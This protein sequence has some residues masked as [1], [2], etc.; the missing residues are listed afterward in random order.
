TSSELE[1]WRSAAAVRQAAD[2]A[3][4]R[5]QADRR[6]V[7][8]RRIAAAGRRLHQSRHLLRRA[9]RSGA[10]R[11]RRPGRTDDGDTDGQ[12]HR[13]DAGQDRPS[14]DDRQG[15]A[16]T[17]R[18]RGDSKASRCLSD[19]GRRRGLPGLE[20]DQ[21]FADRRVRRSGNGGDLRIRRSRHAGNRRR[22]CDRLVGAPDRPARMA[23]AHRQDPG[24]ARLRQRAATLVLT[25]AATLAAPA[26]AAPRVLLYA[27]DDTPQLRA[28]Q[29]GVREALGTT[30][31]VEIPT[32]DAG[33]RLKAAA[34]EDP[35][36]AIITLGPQAAMRAARDA[37]LL[38]TIDCMSTQAGA[39][40]Q[41]VP[42]AIP[43]EQQLTWLKRLLPNARYIGVLYDP[44]QNTE[45]VDALAAA[46]RGTDLNPVLAPVATPAML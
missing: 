41:A 8:A 13:D 2:R 35:D 24:H 23:A 46:L 7:R 29:R 40:A 37:P 16:R 39:S 45:L 12:V 33:A 11:S 32:G 42:A 34:H 6:S 30:P 21:E 20:S 14:R 9:G 28:A 27:T 3:R 43:L 36:A 4:R 25:I 26:L 19:G 38:A 44:A 10:R 1:T 31:I 17:G 18:D 15:R 5:A 22:R